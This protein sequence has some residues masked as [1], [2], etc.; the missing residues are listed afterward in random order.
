MSKFKNEILVINVRDPNKSYQDIAQKV[1]CTRALVSYYLNPNI[2]IR[3]NLNTRRYRQSNPLKNKLRHFTGRKTISTDSQIC[4]LQELQ[5][6]IGINPKCYLTGDPIDIRNTR[7]YEFDHITPTCLGGD[8][9]VSNL[10]IATN[11]ANRAKAA[12]PLSDFLN[13]CRKTLENHG[14]EVTKN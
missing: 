3:N 9:T 14:Y 6:K 11:V 1:G 13:L 8:N 2:R 12:L 4:S 7:T 10:G 5:E